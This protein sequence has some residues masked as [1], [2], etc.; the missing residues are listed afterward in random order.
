MEVYALYRKQK[1]GASLTPVSELRG[2]AGVGIEGDCQARASSPRQV[3]VFD[4]SVLDELALEEKAVRANVILDGRIDA[5]PSGALLRV[6]SLTLRLT[7]PC[8]ACRKLEGERPG[9]ARALTGRR[10]MLARVVASGTTRVGDMASV[11]PRQLRALDEDWHSRIADIVTRIPDGMVLTYSTL[12]RIAGVR[13]AERTIRIP[14]VLRLAG[15]FLERHQDAL[16]HA[17]SSS[18]S[19][20][21]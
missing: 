5:L 18:S 20:S 10:G 19:A 11:A 16:C 7:I 14:E 15:C 4:R 9:L 21:Q 12:A 6:G 17:A 2:I 8:E 3:L 1:L 13:V